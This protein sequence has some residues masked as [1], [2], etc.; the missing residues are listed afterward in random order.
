MVCE[1]EVPWGVKEGPMI[2]MP[3]IEVIVRVVQSILSYLCPIND[4]D[5]GF[6][7]EEECGTSILLPRQGNISSQ[8]Q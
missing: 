1:G 3:V 5:V 8:V 6:L 4:R 7:T 2:S